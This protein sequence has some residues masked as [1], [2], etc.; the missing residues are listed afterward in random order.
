M[1]FQI[2]VEVDAESLSVAIDKV[3]FANTNGLFLVS[4]IEASCP[5]EHHFRLARRYVEGDACDDA[6]PA[7]EYVMDHWEWRKREGFAYSPLKECQWCGSVTREDDIISISGPAPPVAFKPHRFDF[8]FC[9]D[10]EQSARRFMMESDEIARAKSLLNRLR[11]AT[12][13]MPDR[14]KTWEGIENEYRAGIRSLRDI[15]E[16]YGVS[17]A[18]IRKRAERDRWS[19]GISLNQHTNTCAP[20]AL[21]LADFLENC[22]A[23]V[24]SGIMLEEKAKAISMLAELDLK[25]L[26][27]DINHA[28]ITRRRNWHSMK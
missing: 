11:L 21:W 26:Q 23:E 9:L 22:I 2:T 6:H 5:S 8:H 10:C 3:V 20:S 12:K 19:R 18:A 7:W 1:R 13:G 17:H 14:S 25:I 28:V 16:E 27:L 24:K 4:A 15:G